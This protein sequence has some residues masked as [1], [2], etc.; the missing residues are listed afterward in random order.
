MPSLNESN[1]VFSAQRRLQRAW[2][3][4]EVNFEEGDEGEQNAV[5][6]TRASFAGDWTDA[7]RV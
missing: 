3:R 1:T 5:Y 2:K 4:V 7:M 6:E